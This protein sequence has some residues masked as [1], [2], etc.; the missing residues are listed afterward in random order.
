LEKQR[1]SFPLFLLT[2]THYLL[3]NIK[4]HQQNSRMICFWSLSFIFFRQNKNRFQ[5]WVVDVTKH[6]CHSLDRKQWRKISHQRDKI[7][8]QLQDEFQ[9]KVIVILKGKASLKLRNVT[10]QKSLIKWMITNFVLH[11]SI[12]T[13]NFL[14]WLNQTNL[15][16]ISG[17]I[18]FWIF[19][20]KSINF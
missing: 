3:A 17:E 15:F 16:K 4:R 5:L 2:H 11:K 6:L 9:K 14:N 8:I 20:T 18:I 1:S 10:Q 13:I 7:I 19:G 12:I